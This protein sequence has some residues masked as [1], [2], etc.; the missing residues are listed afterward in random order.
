MKRKQNCSRKASKSAER[1]TAVTQ[2]K[3]LW[4]SSLENGSSLYISPTLSRFSSGRFSCQSSSKMWIIDHSAFTRA[5]RRRTRHFKLTTNLDWTVRNFLFPF[6]WRT[7]T[8]TLTRN[9]TWRG[10]NGHIVNLPLLHQSWN[11]HTILR[12]RLTRRWSHSAQ[13][14]PLFTGI[15]NHPASLNRLL[16]ACLQIRV[17]S[18]RRL[19]FYCGPWNIN[20]ATGN[21]VRNSSGFGEHLNTSLW[22]ETTLRE[23]RVSYEVLDTQQHTAHDVLTY[24]NPIQPHSKLLSRR[25]G[26]T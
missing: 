9:F 14:I 2:T 17:N 25:Q 12:R 21:A 24:G 13:T 15:L 1:S 8:T 19:T 11:P 10:S 5:D 23:N 20:R 7:K 6:S 4:H 26:S 3:Q 16:E 18:G 22:E